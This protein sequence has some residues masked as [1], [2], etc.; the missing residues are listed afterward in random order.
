[1]DRSLVLVKQGRWDLRADVIFAFEAMIVRRL[2]K[3]TVREFACR[4]LSRRSPGCVRTWRAGIANPHAGYVGCISRGGI[5]LVPTC[6]GSA[7]PI[8]G[9]MKWSARTADVVMA[10]ALRDRLHGRPLDNRATTNKD[11]RRSFTR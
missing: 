8:A 10:G 4:G 9:P 6:R 7:D 1:M 5:D 2:A 3:S 11:L